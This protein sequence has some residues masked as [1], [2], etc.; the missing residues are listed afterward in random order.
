LVLSRPRTTIEEEMDRR[1][2]AIRAVTLYCSVE[3]GGMNPIQRGGQSRNAALPV[4]SQLGYK[5]KALEEAKV[6]VFK[7]KRPN[8]CFLCLGNKRLP[9]AQRIR[10]FST[11]GDLSKHLRRK[12]LQCIKSGEGLSC[13]LCKVSLPDKMHVQRHAQEIHATVSPRH[14]YDRS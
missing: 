8:V 1:N 7:D 4:K 13:N 2:R 9:L 12:H 5:E 11:L 14:F 10:P 6:S 3:E